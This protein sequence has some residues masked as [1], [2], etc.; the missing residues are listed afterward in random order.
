MCLSFCL[1]LKVIATLFVASCSASLYG[2]VSSQ[3]QA[4]DGLG[5][6]SWVPQE[7]LKILN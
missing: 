6:Y 4:Q 2:A 3:Y 1:Y 7:F 5:G